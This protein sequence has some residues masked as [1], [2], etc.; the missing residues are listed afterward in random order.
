[1]CSNQ[2]TVSYCNL[3]F[4]RSPPPQLHKSFKL[5]YILCISIGH[6]RNSITAEPISL[7]S[8]HVVLSPKFALVQAWPEAHIETGIQHAFL[9]K[10]R[11]SLI[12]AKKCNSKAESTIR[13]C[14]CG[15]RCFTSQ[16][17]IYCRSRFLLPNL[18]LAP[19][20]HQFG[21]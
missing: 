14:C 4:M 10:V 13:N 20:L 16:L 21:L 11:K 12:E 15:F 6:H 3:L 18:P 7:N 5:P 8:I 2:L 17:S 1:M 19:V 9:E